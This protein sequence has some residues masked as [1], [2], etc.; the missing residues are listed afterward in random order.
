[1]VYADAVTSA[2][3]GVGLRRQALPDA[4]EWLR[5]NVITAVGTMLIK[6]PA[7]VIKGTVHTVH[8]IATKSIRGAGGLV[9]TTGVSIRGCRCR[10]RCPKNAVAPTAALEDETVSV[11]SVSR[12]SLVVGGDGD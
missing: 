1:M 5:H 2:V 4:E 3:M 8:S 9:N 7:K 6:A 12:A 10:C 11:R